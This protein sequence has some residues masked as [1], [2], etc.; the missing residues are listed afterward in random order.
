MCLLGEEHSPGKA[1][2]GLEST[3]RGPVRF[4]GGNMSFFGKSEDSLFKYEL[5]I[6]STH[7]SG[8][9]SRIVGLL[10]G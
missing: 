6:T 1:I 5:R 3:D 4:V 8:Q 9:E 7:F 2:C 10:D